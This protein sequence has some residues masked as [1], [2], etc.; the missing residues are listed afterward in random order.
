MATLT[1]THL[2]LNWTLYSAS[3]VT[4]DDTTSVIDTRE[5]TRV[6]AYGSVELLQL[7]ANTD[8]TASGPGSTFDTMTSNAGLVAQAGSG[9]KWTHIHTSC[10]PP[11]IRFHNTDGGAVDVSILVRR[12]P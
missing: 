8:P 2:G 5:A 4:A 3:S 6:I 12:R 9:D 10:I 7:Q 1:E 11:Y